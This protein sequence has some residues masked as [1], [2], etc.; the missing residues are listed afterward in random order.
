MVEFTGGKRLQVWFTRKRVKRAYI[1]LGN[2]EAGRLIKLDEKLV[3]DRFVNLIVEGHALV[4]GD[5]TLK[6]LPGWRKTL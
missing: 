3:L 5:A 1:V 6:M 2:E 4:R